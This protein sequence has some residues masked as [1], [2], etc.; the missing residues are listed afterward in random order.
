M[1][2]T[3]ENIAAHAVAE[4]LV[5]LQMPDHIQE[6]RGR[7]VGY[8]EQ[9]RKGSYTPLDIFPSNRNQVIRQK[10]LLIGCGGGFQQECSQQF[11]PVAEW[12][13]S[14]DLFLEDEGQ[15]YGS[16]GE[17]ASVA[18]T[19]ATCLE[20][21][22]GD[23]RQ[24]PGGL[25]KSKES[26][27]FRKKLTKRPLALRCQTQYIQAHDFGDVV[28]RYL[29]CPKD[30]TDGSAAIDPA[31]GQFWHELIGDTP[32][33]LSKEIQRA[34]FAI[35]WMGL[36]G[37]REGLP[38]MLAT[39]FAEAAGVTGRQKWGL[40]L[41]SSARVSQVTYQTVVGVRY[42]ELVTFNGTSWRF[43]KYVPQDSPQR[44]GFLPI[45]WDVPRANI[46]A[47][48][49]IG[50]VVDWLTERC[51]F[52]AD[53]KSNLAVL[54]NRN[55]MTNLFR[56]SNWVS[57]SHDSI[58]SRG[59][60]TCAG[61][62]AHTVLLAQTKVGFLT[63]G[64][65]KF[66]LALPEDEQM[67]QLEEAYARATVAITRARAL[68]LIMGPLDMKGLLGAATV[69]GTL[70]YGAGHVWAGHAHFYL[71]DYELSRSPTDE[72][73]IDMLKQNCCLSG[74]H[75]PP[76]AIVE[77]L[78]D[79]VTH[80]HKVRRL[81]L[82][83]VDLW[84]PWKYNT[85]RA[86][87]I[88]DQLWRIS[89]NDDTRRVSPFRPEGPS[90]PLRCRRFAYGYALDGSECPSYLVWLQRDGQ[91]YTLLD[92]S[93]ADT[94][95][96]DQNFFRSLGMQHF[97]DSFALVSQICVRREALALFG[98]R[99]D[100]L[101]PDLHI[102]RDGVLRIGLGAHQEHRVNHEARAADRTKVSAEVIQ[103]AAHEVDPEPDKAESDGATSD[104][105]GSESASDSEQNDPPSSLAADAE[106][107][108]LLQTSYVAVGKDFHDQEDLIG[109]EVQQASETGAGS[110]EMASGEV[111][112]FSTKMCGPGCCWE[113][114]ATRVNS[115][116]SLPSLHQVA[117][118][119]TME[120]AV[121]L[122]KEVAAILRAVLTHDTKKLYNDGTVH[123]LCS[124]YWIQPIYQEL[125]HSSSRYNAAREGERKR[126]SSG[127]ARVAAHPRP[128]KKRKPSASGTSF[129]DWIGG[130]CYA[131]TLQVW[132]PAHWAPVVLQQLQQK[133][134]SYRAEN[135]SWMDQEEANRRM[136]FKVGNYRD[137]DWE[138]NIRMLTGTIKA[139]W[140][141]LP[142]ERYL[143]ALPTLR[144]GVIAGVFRN[145]GAAPWG[146]TR[147]E[148]LQLSVFLP[149]DMSL[150]D[151]YAGVYAL[152]T[153]WPEAS[154]LGADYLRKVAGY[155][156]HLLRKKYD[157]QSMWGD[158]D[159]QWRLLKS[160]VETKGPGWYSPAEREE[161]LFTNKSNRPGDDMKEALRTDGNTAAWQAWSTTQN[162]L[163]QLRQ[164]APPLVFPGEQEIFRAMY[165]QV[166]EEEQ[167]ISPPYTRIQLDASMRGRKKRKQ[168]EDNVLIG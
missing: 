72:T 150:D 130:I 22:S 87:E 57:S 108:E 53:A 14:V 168:G 28:M 149:N 120:L 65:K 101:L 110:W 164:P 81:H 32:P 132:F 56:A 134:D 121:Y 19:P 106:Q 105:E 155:D 73:F 143:A 107:Y 68:C 46:H 74:P 97:Y 118:C 93:T 66:L 47:V 167:V 109:T 165:A 26:K 9:N 45:F 133:E 49:D 163:R 8:Y 160:Q 27:A 37:E 144:H 100:E 64:R 92:T 96:L 59:V 114:Q 21:W 129:C 35:L 85:A 25:K 162:Q 115:P 43:G 116:E 90:P 7:L 123:L 70:M 36:R 23:H 112:F 94:L 141:Q 61:M 41:S 44:G 54:H 5:S 76:P 83:V 30:L 75:F 17:A 40:V 128:P 98:L 84:R 33:C 18:R 156:F 122:A 2:L 104:S 126:P 137:G 80:Y 48:E 91:S 88:T 161:R 13:G 166:G 113:V 38:S 117:K 86:R 152:P 51:E 127:L 67:V 142:V 146:I 136:Q 6:K 24:T 31:V 131:D 29:D 124:N 12:M 139:D 69:M 103:L 42:P 1:V 153:V 58:V 102:T 77:A 10:L 50:A 140:I 52:H 15:Q 82:I 157:V 138:S 71:H 89:H 55:D 151:W 125:L 159:P 145:K 158:L 39:S 99:E 79:Y 34:A 4:H 111:I 63:G 3:K 78:Q 148:K 62:T 60:T 11:S 95:V 119:L 16:M 20:V 135:P 154:M 147:A